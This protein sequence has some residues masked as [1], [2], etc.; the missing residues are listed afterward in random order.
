VPLLDEQATSARTGAPPPLR[1]EI[2]P[3][4]PFELFDRYL[5]AAA[6]RCEQ[7]TLPRWGNRLAE[8]AVFTDDNCFAMVES[9]RIDSNELGPFGDGEPTPR[10]SDN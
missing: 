2:G 4:R 6:T 10:R 7:L 1:G 3:T 8:A 9:L 5:Q